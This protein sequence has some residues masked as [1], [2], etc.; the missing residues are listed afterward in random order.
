MLVAGG[1]TQAT[2]REIERAREREGLSFLSNQR[3]GLYPSSFLLLVAMPF[4][5]S[6]FL[7]RS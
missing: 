1:D 5:P 7:L 2:G 4:V 6:S 3:N